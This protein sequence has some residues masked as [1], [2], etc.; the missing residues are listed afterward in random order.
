MF[1]WYSAVIFLNLCELVQN[2]W[3]LNVV[4]IQKLGLFLAIFHG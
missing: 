2:C 3:K 4:G 1:C